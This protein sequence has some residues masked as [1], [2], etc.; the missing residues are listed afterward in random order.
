MKQ[1]LIPLEMTCYDPLH[2]SGIKTMAKMQK[3]VRFKSNIATISGEVMYN[4]FKEMQQT[5]TKTLLLNVCCLLK[6]HQILW[7]CS[8]M[9]DQ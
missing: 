4:V 8:V 6:L 9:T 3:T 5:P 2:K 7:V 1:H